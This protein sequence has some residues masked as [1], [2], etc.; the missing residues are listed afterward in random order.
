MNFSAEDDR[1]MLDRLLHW[2]PDDWPPD[3][4]RPILH[5]VVG[6]SNFHCLFDRLTMTLLFPS[7]DFPRSF[8]AVTIRIR[9]AKGATLRIFGTGSVT[10]CGTSSQ[11]GLTYSMQVLRRLLLDHGF[12]VSLGPI[13]YENQVYSYYIGHP[14]DNT[15]VEVSGGSISV[16][17]PST[18]PGLVLQLNHPHLRL[19]LFESGNLM[20]TGVQ[21]P[22][23]AELA[24]QRIRPLTDQCRP[25][26]TTTV[27]PGERKSAERV[28]RR[29]IALNSSGG[30]K[31][32]EAAS[33]RLVLRAMDMITAENNGRTFDAIEYNRLLDDTLAKLSK[34]EQQ[35]KRKQAEATQARKQKRQKADEDAEAAAQAAEPWTWS[36]WDKD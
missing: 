17:R 16:N 22:S 14:I 32:V 7:A 19:L 36:N 34:A 12:P 9:P 1:N 31:R 13:V 26:S 24:V 15:R 30:N 20:I 3:Q 6:Q 35:R 25:L 23:D 10:C 27:S 11:T 2:E 28:R 4:H 29:D 5:N 8:P 18:F 21:R 33:S